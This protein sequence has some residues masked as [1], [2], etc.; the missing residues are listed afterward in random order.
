[1]TSAEWRKVKRGWPTWSAIDHAFYVW[2]DDI[3]HFGE[4]DQA[5]NEWSCSRNFSN[6]SEYR[7]SSSRERLVTD[8][9]YKFLML[10]MNTVQI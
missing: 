9:E 3:K 8:D 7:G 2:F 5:N 4:Y 6:F 1:M 10:E